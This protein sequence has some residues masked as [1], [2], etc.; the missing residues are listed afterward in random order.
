MSDAPIRPM[1]WWQVLLGGIAVAAGTF[2][3]L[4]SIVIL[5]WALEGV[6]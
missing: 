2:A 1:P 3:L 6:A 5:G 4:W